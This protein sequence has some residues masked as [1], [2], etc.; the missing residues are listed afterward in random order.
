MRDRSKELGCADSDSEPDEHKVLVE[1]SQN[2]EELDRHFFE[3]TRQIRESLQLLR[4]KVKDLEASQTTVLS[5]PLPEDSMKKDLQSLREEIKVLSKDIRGKLQKI[6]VKDDDEE[7][8]GSVHKRMK[9]TQH[10]VL[11]QQ[12]IEVINQCNVIQTQYK[13]SNVKRI[14]RQ[15]QITGHN[16]TDEQFDEMLES[17]QSDVFT[18]NLLKDTQITKQAL[19]EI[20]SRHDEILKLEKSIVEL[21]DMFMLLSMEVEA[22][23]ETIDNNIEKKYFTFPPNYVEK[24]RK[25]L[26]AGG[27][28]STQSPARKRFT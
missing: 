16:V 22:Q 12:F 18:C 25:Q 11:C 3:T 27:E 2:D 21:H 8:R 23:G 26:E 7:V 1:P 24:G 6:E 15:L 28:N 5:Q 20:E 9:K 14:K 10:G 19:N 13:E 17:G 4:S